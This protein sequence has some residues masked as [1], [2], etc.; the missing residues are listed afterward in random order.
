MNVIS[1]ESLLVGPD[2]K[3]IATNLEGDAVEKA[4][5]DALGK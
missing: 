4:V 1:V 3:I 5:A 2:G